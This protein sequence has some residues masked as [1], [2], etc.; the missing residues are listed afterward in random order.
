[1]Y[2]HIRYITSFFVKRVFFRRIF[3]I[4]NKRNNEIY[5]DNSFNPKKSIS[6][7]LKDKDMLVTY[8]SIFNI[9]YEIF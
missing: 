3:G 4:N 1:M 7:V 9:S 6:D 8:I 2:I 5:L